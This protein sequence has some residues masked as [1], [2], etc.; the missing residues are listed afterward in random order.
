MNDLK[1]RKANIEK[2]IEELKKIKYWSN[3]KG[4]ELVRKSTFDVVMLSNGYMIPIDKERIETMFCF[5]Y[6]FNGVSSLEDD[7]NASKMAEHARTDEEY[8]ISKNM[9]SI[10]D[11]I[12]DLEKSP[13]VI[14]YPFN[15]EKSPIKYYTTYKNEILLENEKYY[16]SNGFEIITNEDKQKIIDVLNGCKADLEKRLKTYL[17]RYGLSKIQTW[18]YLRD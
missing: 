6:G 8:F 2:Y 1:T 15:E 10:N 18:T 3:E 7:E 5:G 11:K 13:I 4:Y 9:E 16:Y 12:K 17:K 14:V